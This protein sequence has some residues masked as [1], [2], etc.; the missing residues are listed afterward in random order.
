MVKKSIYRLLSR[1]HIRTIRVY[2]KTRGVCGNLSGDK[3]RQIPPRINT[4]ITLNPRIAIDRDSCH[5]SSLQR[6][7]L[8]PLNKCSFS[9]IVNVNRKQKLLT[10]K[11]V[12]TYITSFNNK[13]RD[14]NML[15]TWL[16]YYQL[17]NK[18]HSCVSKLLKF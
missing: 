4:M 2:T 14:Q 10:F 8:A 15:K 1:I 7:S 13:P 17:R 3:H 6:E 11:T 16:L 18:Y 5:T 12:N 9:T